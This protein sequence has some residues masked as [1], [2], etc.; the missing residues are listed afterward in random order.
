MNQKATPNPFES[1]HTYDTDLYIVDYTEQTREDKR[2]H[3]GVEL[4]TQQLDDISGLHISNPNRVVFHVV[5][6]EEANNIDFFT[7]QYGET[8]SQCECVGLAD[9]SD[10]NKRVWSIAVELKYPH[11]KKGINRNKG[12]AKHQVL[13]TLEFLFDA[14]LLS[15]ENVNYLIVSI[16]R[17]PRS[18]FGGFHISPHDKLD[19]RR[20]NAFIKATNVVYIEDQERL[21]FYKK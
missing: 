3:R 16:P 21:R 5:N 15:K 8:I 4:H 19:L 11:S 18:V 20:M 7:N 1:V 13:S 10:V 17:F 2:N 6:I 12:K 14:G 9:K